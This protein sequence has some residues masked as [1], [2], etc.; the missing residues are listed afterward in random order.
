MRRRH[1]TLATLVLTLGLGLGAVTPTAHAAPPLPTVMASSG[2]SITRGFDANLLCLLRDCTQY[3]WSTGTSVRSHA[4]FVKSLSG[5]TVTTYNWAR[6]GAK[7]R[8]LAGQFASLG[9]LKTKPQ[10]L[11]ILMGANDVCTSSVGTMTSAADFR[12][13]FQAAL[14]RIRTS[15]SR[16][17]IFVSSIPNVYQLWDVLK[18]NSQAQSAWR[19]Y[20]ICQSMLSTANTEEVRQQVLTHLQSLNAILAELCGATTNCRY[21]G[22]ATYR[23]A[24]VAADISTIDYFHPSTA[25]QTKLA[26]VTWQASYWVA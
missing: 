24:F 20:G 11:T 1:L 9:T 25:G 18:G 21:D 5:K 19:S 26:S 8:D 4:Q 16:T 22:G 2:D 15:S 6:T 10:Y 17:L 3:S 7:M 23:T 12:V 14:D 13:Q